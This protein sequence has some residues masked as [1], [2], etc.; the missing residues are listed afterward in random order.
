MSRR[1]KD[2]T[3]FRYI[4]CLTAWLSLL[5]LY[6]QRINLSIGIIGMTKERASNKTQTFTCPVRYNKTSTLVQ[7]RTEKFKLSESM[8]NY[9]LLAYNVGYMIG[10]VPGALLSITID[11]SDNGVIVC[12]SL[13]IGLLCNPFVYMIRQWTFRPLYPIVHE[14]IGSH[15][16][17]S[18][19]TFLTLFTHIRN[20]VSL[21]IILPIGG[22]F[23]NNF[24]DGWKYVFFL[25]EALDILVKIMWRLFVYLEPEENP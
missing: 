13:S 20:L 1:S 19:Q 17:Q 9:V 6:S 18:E 5:A 25:S 22:L 3:R 24:I 15:S 14:T 11:H 16:P 2:F 12:G 10:H 4:V 21:A 23:I 7:N 8:Q